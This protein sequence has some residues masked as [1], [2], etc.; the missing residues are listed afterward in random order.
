MMNVNLRGFKKENGTMEIGEGVTRASRAGGCPTRRKMPRARYAA[1]FF[2]GGVIL[3]LL[4][5]PAWAAKDYVLGA[6]D[7]I[8]VS[9]W[10]NPELGVTVPVRPDGKIS[11]PLGGDIKA[12]GRTP[13]GL[14]KA[15]VEKLTKFIK[16]PTVSI[17]VMAINSPKIFL[18][19]KREGTGVMTLR[20]QTSILQLI[21]Q[22]GPANSIDLSRA[23]IIRNDRRLNLDLRYLVETGDTRSNLTLEPGDIIYLPDAF[24]TRITVIGEV[25]TPSNIPFRPGLTVVDALIE[26]GWV[27]EFA[28]LKKV[29]VVRERDGKKEEMYINVARVKSGGDA[30]QDLFL[31]PG[32]LVIVKESMF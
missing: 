19:G 18:L 17:V 22:L 12:A 2:W 14:Q 21:A 9:V 1:L 16:D 6:E 31:L 24:T 11:L 30:E 5:A 3:C 26:A 29:L 8:Q 25:T 13:E 27:T 10:G 28:N 23:Y 32:D 15:I 7:V 20:S 4:T